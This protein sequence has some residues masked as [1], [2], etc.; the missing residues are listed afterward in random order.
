M[1]AGKLPSDLLAELLAQVGPPDPSVVVGPGIGMDAAVL[2]FGGERLLVAKTDPITFAT[3]EIGWYAVQ[4]NANDV[5]VMGASPRW[6]L[7][8]ALLPEGATEALAREI[9]GQIRAA[10]DA[11]RITLV[12]GHTEIT[13]GLSRPILVGALLGE[14]E[15]GRLV[16]AAGTRP[17]DIL[18]LTKGVAIEGTAVLAREVP[19]ELRRRG[20]GEETI[21][22]GRRYIREPG[23][24][25]AEEARAAAAAGA[26]AM[27][28]PTEGG[29]I[30]AIHEMAEAS[31]LGV[32]VR[33]EAIPVL[34]ETTEFCAALGLDPLGLLAS[35]ALL[36]AAAPE[37][38]AALCG[39]IA[40]AGV[41]VQ[42]IGVFVAPPRRTIIDR[43]GARRPLPRFPRDEVARFFAERGAV[44]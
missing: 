11:L 9:F 40:A 16:T 2:D 27:H 43:R 29:V 42:E 23:I 13:V 44:S 8:T 17:G 37:R 32:E 10:C 30:T 25:V 24:G 7:V 6:L 5:A 28:D 4:V 39:A 36:V 34:A 15:R 1:E 12:G 21:Q 19:Q 31:G 26:H 3:D 35:G 33:L 38:A 18:L 41:A 14:V 20:V 22:R